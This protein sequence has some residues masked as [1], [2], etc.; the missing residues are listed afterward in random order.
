MEIDGDYTFE[1]SQDVVWEA[2]QD[3][4]VLGAVVPGG[5]GFTQIGENQY[6]GNLQIKVGP[7]QGTFEGKINLLN[8][9]PPQ[10]YT[11]EVDGKGAPGFVKATGNMSLE[12]ISPTQTH[13]T[14]TGQ[15][16][17]GGRI[18]S[19]GQRL[20]ES[21]ARSIIRQSLDA[22]NEYLKVKVAAQP[23]V[24]TV[25]AV[26]GAEASVS[27][28][29]ATEPTAPEMPAAPSPTP[30]PTTYKPPSQF[31]LGMNVARDVL[32]DI[33]PP[34]YQSLALGALIVVI[35]LI[36]WLLTSRPS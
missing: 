17:V 3:P 28:G 8:I 1:I 15:A 14:Y 22:L 5:Q 2:L 13:M 25:A 36:I 18:A 19:V 6:T 33:I 11:I 27:T 35:L 4:N 31:Q 9:V 16:Q 12:A 34:K 29:V 23:I 7:V 10:S 32:G 26:G 24:E 21:A 20:M 30:V